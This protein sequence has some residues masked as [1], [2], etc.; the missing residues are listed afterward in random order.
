MT[1]HSPQ[2]RKG[3]QPSKA[4]AREVVEKHHHHHLTLPDAHLLAREI[5]GFSL[6]I[7][8][9]VGI[10]FQAVLAKL[11]FA[12]GVD[13]LAVL[14]LRKVIFLA[15]YMPF[16]F[17]RFRPQTVYAQEKYVLHAMLVG[18]LGHYV[19]PLITFHALTMINAGVVTVVVYTYPLFVILLN[20][21]LFQIFP[22]PL[23]IF[24]FLLMQ[25][26]VYWAMGGGTMVFHQN[27]EGSLLAL[28]VAV[29]YAI[30]TMTMHKAVARLGTRRYIFHAVMGGFLAS[31][32]HFVLVGSPVDSLFISSGNMVLMVLFS[33]ACFVPAL[34]VAEGIQAIGVTRASLITSI[35]PVLTIGLAYVFLGEVLLK[36]QVLGGLMVV[37]AVVL[38][39][40][41][42]LRRFL[43]TT[44]RTK[45][46]PS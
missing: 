39:E 45:V 3:K 10:G 8:A 44:R 25:L 33:L 40:K 32:L 29:L 28:L 1:Q 36:R 42:L 35:S 27:L 43:P 46:Q 5:R 11:L 31:L 13:M 7:L 15:I 9:T 24:T 19:L 34:F 20:A 14:V 26:G 30:F 38:L 2:K 37:G 12:Q 6:I 4:K 18:A 23:H 17:H 41:N 16:L 22:P 21:L